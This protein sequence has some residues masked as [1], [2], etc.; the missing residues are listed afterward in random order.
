MANPSWYRLAAKAFRNVLAKKQSAYGDVIAWLDD[1]IGE[2]TA[3]NRKEASRLNGIA[4][5][6]NAIFSDY[7]Y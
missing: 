5:K 7:R 3:R 2:S 4:N 1:A 6:G